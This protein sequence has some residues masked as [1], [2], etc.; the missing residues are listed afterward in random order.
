MNQRNCAETVDR[1]QKGVAL[2]M[3]ICGF[4]YLAIMAEDLTP[5]GTFNDVLDLI[6]M[7]GVV[8]TMSVTLFA[9][10]PALKQKLSGR[11]VTNSEPEGFVSGAMLSSF[12]NGWIATTFSITMLLSFS[13]QLEDLGLGI[14]FYFTT[15]FAVEVLSVSISFFWITR[16]DKQEALEE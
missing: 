16:D 7:V 4:T 8:L 2:G 12:K 15:L 9:I 6:V 3:L 10:W 11:L 13:S 5:K 1:M 14:R